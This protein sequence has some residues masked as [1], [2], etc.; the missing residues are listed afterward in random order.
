MRVHW[1]SGHTVT[2]LYEVILVGVKDNCC[3]SSLSRS[4]QSLFFIATIHRGQF[5]LS[6]SKAFTQSLWKG[7]L[8]RFIQYAAGHQFIR[9]Q[10]YVTKISI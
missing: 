5:T 2:A 4:V 3:E 1:V 6:K 8:V 9:R 10:V 7:P